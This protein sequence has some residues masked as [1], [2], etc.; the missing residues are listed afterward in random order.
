LDAGGYGSS[1]SSYLTDW[2]NNSP[3][4]DQVWIAAWTDDEYNPNATVW[5]VVCLSNSLWANNQRLRQYAG[6]HNETWG[7]VSLNIDSNVFDTTVVGSPEGR[8]W[9]DDFGL[10]EPESGWL[11]FGGR[12]SRQGLGASGWTGNLASGFDRNR[13]SVPGSEARLGCDPSKIPGRAPTGTN[14]RRRQAGRRLAAPDGSLDQEQIGAAYIE[15]LDASR[16]WVAV[17]LQS[18]SS[19]SLGRLYASLDGGL[20]W[21]ARALPLG[22]AVHFESASEGWTAGGPLGVDYYRTEDGGRTWWRVGPPP[23]NGTEYGRQAPYRW[24]SGTI[25]TAGFS[26]GGD[27]H[28]KAHRF[29]S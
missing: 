2:S 3:A 22:E 13:R 10:W 17:R 20:S 23:D 4:P 28:G 15:V 7:G 5:N 27:L 11:Q 26:S 6:G 18:G 16:I 8:A 24:S 25:S 14:G 9:V 1:C 29:A 19:F 21:E 12:P